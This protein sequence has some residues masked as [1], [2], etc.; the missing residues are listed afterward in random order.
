M[1]NID[2]IKYPTTTKI[3]IEEL[4]RAC[5]DYISHK[6]NEYELKEIIWIWA[7]YS[8]D[9]LFKSPTEFNPT[10]RQRVGTKRLNLV[11]D[12]LV[13]YQYKF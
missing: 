13:G 10:L 3:L 9:K 7:D 11:A 4:I 1:K 8:Y 6:I 12:I 2:Y 5:D